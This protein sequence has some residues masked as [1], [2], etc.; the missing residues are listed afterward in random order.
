M[1]QN[2]LVLNGKWVVKKRMLAMAVMGAD[3]FLI[4]RSPLSGNTLNLGAWYGFQEVFLREPKVPIEIDF[5]FTISDGSYLDLTYDRGKRDYSGIRLSRDKTLPPISFKSD[6]DGRFLSTKEIILPEITAGWHSVSFFCSKSGISLSLDSGEPIFIDS[7]LCA[8]GQI[9]FRAGLDGAKVDDVVVREADGSVFE[10]SFRN[11]KNL[12]RIIFLNILPAW[13]LL[14]WTFGN[15]KRRLLDSLKIKTFLIFNFFI[16]LL[17][18][19]GFDFLYWSKLPF[20]VGMRF[21]ST[22][23]SVPQ[24]R[25]EKFRHSLFRILAGGADF[26][27]K[28]LEV[29]QAQGY[30]QKRVVRG[31]IFCASY[32]GEC[33]SYESSEYLKFVDLKRN[34]R[35]LVF[36]GTSQTVGAGSDLLENTFFA[37]THNALSRSLLPACLE[38]LNISISG[39]NLPKLRSD[40]Q[41]VLVEFHPEF[42]LANLSNNDSVKGFFENLSALVAQNKRFGADTIFIEEANAKTSPYLLEKHEMMRLVGKR[43]Q[44]PVF[45]LHAF[46]N[47]PS[48][49]RSGVIWWDTVH[50]SAYGQSLAASWLVPKVR[51]VMRLHKVGAHKISSETQHN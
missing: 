38:S 46:L 44:V 40:L 15:N 5:R 50:L 1:S 17:I 6:L 37:K 8:G 24:L 29:I 51:S 28:L 27:Q 18:L 10:D 36:L 9:G 43:Y 4:S 32:R 26:N 39:S 11:S 41:N 42:V 30:P 48:I 35:R 22:D 31:P 47:E 14:I 23:M 34:C 3:E 21:I 13:F 7:Q 2:T 16:F 19:Y 49:M 45:S 20:Q 33:Q 12:L 25:A